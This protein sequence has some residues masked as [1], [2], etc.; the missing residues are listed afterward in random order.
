M[1]GRSSQL[2]SVSAPRPTLRAACQLPREEAERVATTL[3]EGLGEAIAVSIFEN[4]CSGYTLAVDFDDDDERAA[5]ARIAALLGDEPA[6]LFAFET[7]QPRDWVAAGLAELRPVRAG[8]FVVHGSHDRAKVRPN[9][10]N[11]EIEAALAFG[12]GHHGTTRGCLLAFDALI[13]AHRPRR[14]LDIGTGTGVLAIAALKALRRSVLASDIDPRAGRAARD[15]AR[16]N[17]AGSY[18]TVLQAAGVL[19]AGFR[20][21]AP[22]DLV[23]ANILLEPLKRLAQPLSRIVAPNGK[24]ILSGLLSAQGRTALAFYRARGF[25]LEA[26]M[27]LEGW[28]TFVLARRRRR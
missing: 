13:K 18:V 6:S 12:T 4:A 24:L 3:S 27:S 11:I 7:V 15:N 14:L 23:F 17:G 20:K 21:R 16:G 2:E 25:S 26:R 8:R 22:Y 5:R 10:I 9:R 28:T 19:G 1:S